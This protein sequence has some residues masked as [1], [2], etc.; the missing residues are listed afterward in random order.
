MLTFRK[1]RSGLVSQTSASL[2]STDVAAIAVSSLRCAGG[3]PCCGG[4]IPS[5]I[6]MLELTSLMWLPSVKV[7]RGDWAGRHGATVVTLSA[8]RGEWVGRHGTTLS[9]SA[10]C[11]SVNTGLVADS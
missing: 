4:G 1:R 3:I 11:A 9:L 8:V 6:R 10:V 5:G 7:A 2:L